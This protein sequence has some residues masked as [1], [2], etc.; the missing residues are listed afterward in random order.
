M[1]NRRAISIEDV[2]RSTTGPRDLVRSFRRSLK[3]FPKAGFRFA[4][5]GALVFGE[6][7]LQ[8]GIAL[9][10][11]RLLN[12]PAALDFG[13]LLSGCV[14]ILALIVVARFRILMLERYAVL[15]RE[16]LVDRLSANIHAG[17]YE[18]LAAV[19]MAALRE[20]I[21]TDAPQVSRFFL[22]AWSQVAT[23]GFWL[24][25]GLAAI[26]WLSP[27]LFG[28]ALILLL[29]CGVILLWAT[30]RHMKLAPERFKRLADLSQSARDIAEIDRI[31]L[32]RQF[33]LGD[34]F[35]RQFSACNRRFLEIVFKQGRLRAS[36]RS[37]LLSFNALGLL[38]LLVLGSV[39]VA[40]GAIETGALLVAF[41]VITQLL[42]ACLGLGELTAAAAEAATASKR[43]GAY[44]ESGEN[45][46]PTQ[47]EPVRAKAVAAT[48]LSFGY[49]DSTSIISDLNLRL[50]DRQLT[51]L[52]AATGRGKTT[53]ALLLTGILRPTS[54]SATVVDEKGGSARPATR[55]DILYVGP[56]PILVAGSIRDNLFGGDPEDPLV[57]P[58]LHPLYKEA[59]ITDCDA[60]VIDSS[61]HGVS[62]GQAQL[63]Q[64]ARAILRDPC[65]I[66][67][68]EATGC[69]DME[70]EAEVQKALL[71]WCRA[72]ISLVITH[73]K[74]PWLEFADEQIA[75]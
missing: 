63:I 58:V 66:V 29:L 4:V 31:L 40:R 61:G 75:L 22:E 52:T 13:L 14:A 56:K 12:R 2:L 42:N 59:K 57:A 5:L 15:W 68:D 38:G 65:F 36:A 27:P 34:R 32:S 11:S 69:L 21:M 33:A 17:N 35:F 54:G 24:L 28:F 48:N 19:P 16:R 70:T 23:V 49:Q 30:V 39:L 43:M 1:S 55:G 64:L 47:T 6:V 8:V 60:A 44:W 71:E 18:D 51:V 25:I 20:I 45:L 72:R 26:A 41:F 7:G 9:V 53:L 74:C 10:A 3:A 67:F 62:S 37:I 73:R 46:S 50:K